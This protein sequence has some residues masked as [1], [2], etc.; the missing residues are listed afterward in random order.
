MVPV[1]ESIKRFFLNRGWQIDQLHPA[2]FSVRLARKLGYG[3]YPL[4][5]AFPVEPPIKGEDLEVL[6][7]PE[8]QRSV[9]MV[10]EHTLLD[11][12][13]LANLWNLA[14]QTGPG[15]IL[16]AG[17]FRGGGALHLA[18]ACLD[19]SV[20][21]FDTFEGFRRL[22]PGLDDVFEPHWFQD[23]TQDHVRQLFRSA[24][25]EAT[26]VKGYFPESAEGL[27]LGPVAFCHLDVDLYEA[28]RDGLG[29][30]AD[31]LAPRS[32]IVID[33]FHRGAHGVDK[34]L[35]EFLEA[36]PSFN[37]FPMFPGQAMLFS[38]TLWDR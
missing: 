35:S 9:R 19:R 3:L 17:A 14:R 34:A 32:L 5:P 29:F 12:A 23:T 25:R 24:G 2:R 38:R 20:F 27:N 18:N 11:V 10:R 8:F 36:H 31:R 15:S 22:S 21:V 26:I 30:L 6:G 37:C 4:D 1:K 13:R 7:D 28:T 33:D 16:E